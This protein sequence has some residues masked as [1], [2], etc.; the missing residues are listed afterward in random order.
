MP[1]RIA[2]NAWFPQPELTECSLCR[3]TRSVL[4]PTTAALA[5]EVALDLM[6]LGRVPALLGAALSR[7]ARGLGSGRVAVLVPEA[8]GKW[9]VFASSDLDQTHDLMIDSDRYPEL[10]EVRRTGVPFI[11]RSV[12]S[13]PNLVLSR[14]MLAAAGVRAVAVF[15]IFLA[16]PSGEPVV[17]KV[18]LARELDPQ[19]E[20][21]ATLVAHLLVHRLALLPTQEAAHQLGLSS[22]PAGGPNPA[23]LLRLVP[24]P[25]LVVDDDGR[26]IHAN[27]RAAWMLRGREGRTSSGSVILRLE[28]ERIWLGQDPR[29][30][31]TLVS[32]SHP[33]L[34]GWSNRVGENRTLVLLDQHPEERRHS[35]DSRIRSA[36]AQKLHELEAANTLLEEHARKRARF[37]S[38]VAHELKTPL[39]IQRS[40][41]ETLS[42]DLSEGLSQEQREFLA[43]ALHG[44]E[45]LHRL[46]EELLDLAALESGNLPLT[47]E[48]VSSEALA[49]QVIADLEPLAER[50]GVTLRRD[51]DPNATIRADRERLAQVL[52][53]L[54][55]NGIKYGRAGG[56]VT[57]LFER[58]ADRA[59]FTVRDNGIGIPSDALP[60]IFEEFVRAPGNT[61]SDG[62]GLGLAIVRRSVMAMGGRVWVDS[63][64]GRGSRFFVELPLWTGER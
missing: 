53:N 64:T 18:S 32:G 20:A 40:Y 24:V 52:R 33:R 61:A 28:P 15:P 54:V 58:L 55:E 47:L 50:H 49:D 23:A 45:R 31:A 19:D 56:E 57:V 6:A 63:D 29:W 8:G 22:A 46:V 13:T 9:R 7:L 21:F 10:L 25:A 11:A 60:S 3:E 27:P 62:V 35:Q 41:L 14:Q 26:V 30:E 34:L 37:V 12:D 16:A 59:L 39:A 38:D 42:G 5:G 1:E 4:A 48:P 43:A 51:G 17:L 36:L 44:A 2:V